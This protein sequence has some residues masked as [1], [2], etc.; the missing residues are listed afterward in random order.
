MVSED[1]A[2]DSPY[3]RAMP[4]HQGGEGRFIP[5]LDVASKELPVGQPRPVLK[6]DGSAKMLH[7]SIHP[8]GRHCHVLIRS[9]PG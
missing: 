9:V 3:H 7:D 2:A 5:M 4:P 8:T 6:K 1:P